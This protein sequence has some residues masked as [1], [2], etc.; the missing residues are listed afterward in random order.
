M[1]PMPDRLAPML[2]RS[3]GLPADDGRWAHEVKWDGVRAIVYVRDG[4]VRLSSRSLRDITRHYPELHDPGSLGGRSAVLD[5]E[6][7]ALDEGGRPDFQLLQRRMHV[8]DARSVAR[9]EQEVP[10]V[11]VVFDLLW[12]DGRTWM[13]ER[14]DAR[15]EALA[16]LELDAPCWTAPA[17]HVGQGEALLA[18]SRERGLEGIVAKRLDCP[19]TPGRRSAG[20][21]KVKNVRRT[22]LVIG[23]WIP[24]EGR[25]RDRI[26]ALMVG[27]H[28]D[29]AFK[30]AGRVG[31]GFDE[32][33][34]DRLAGLL[35]P[36]ERP[37]PAF[38]GR[39]GPRTAIYVEPR[40][41]CDVE[42]VEWTRERTLRAPS[43]KG[44]RDDIAPGDV[45]FDD[46][47]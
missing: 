11:L 44:L 45:A 26:G 29:G 21:V 43:Y 10:V 41:V 40:L 14:Y 42:F 35:V 16:A 27:Y 24:G 33:E 30:Y 9:L 46:G 5:G 6:V 4:E 34:L 39:R 23:G 22:S 28:E 12:M 17:H 31:T 38:T 1:D 19:Y 2:A 8:T 7:V 36:L 18:A 32:R 25:R 20:W 47:A 15:R 37:T 13:P 3:G